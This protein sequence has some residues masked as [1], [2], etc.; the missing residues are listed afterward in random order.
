MPLTWPFCCAG[1]D[2]ASLLSIPFS[3][4]LNPGS[5][6]TVEVWVRPAAS[7]VS[8]GSS[9]V[10]PLVR[11][12]GSD[13]ASGYA[14]IIDTDGKFAFLLG[15]GNAST[16]P[17]AAKRTGMLTF[18]TGAYE[19][20]V[21]TASA[22]A[23]TWA[24]VSGT[25]EPGMMRLYVNG[26]AVCEEA[27][28]ETV[29]PNVDGD[30][31]LG[32]G[33]E[34]ASDGQCGNAT[35]HC[36][37]AAACQRRACQQDSTCSA[38]S[39]SLR[40]GGGYAGALDEAIVYGRCMSPAAVMNHASANSEKVFATVGASSALGALSECTGDCFLTFSAAS[41]P[42]LASVSPEFGWEG[43]TLTI[44]G[45]GFVDG[46]T[47]KV[48]NMTCA[49]VGTP[50]E[51]EI[52]C[53]LSTSGGVLG[54]APVSVLVPGKGR[55]SNSLAFTVKAQY[56]LA[57]D[58]LGVFYEGGASLTLSGEGLALGTPTVLVGTYAC[59]V[60]SQ[61]TKEIKCLLPLFEPSLTANSQPLPIQISLDDRPAIC[62]SG[63]TLSVVSGT[64][65]SLSAASPATVE[66][67]TTLTLTGQG[68]PV[69]GLLEV[70]VGG[71]ACTVTGT[72]S[73]TEVRLHT[74]SIQS[75]ACTCLGRPCTE[76]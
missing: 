36:A 31:I 37:A 33:C 8:S 62:L 25:W 47:V 42:S 4:A 70:L 20:C 64:P 61:T 27:T 5:G 11:A 24:H 46:T 43:S 23:D 66:E 59:S 18:A 9:T 44:V 63:C 51:T 49:V 10:R 1:L 39:E 40:V 69:A 65:P 56:S 67:G 28:G 2:G 38:A 26:V 12:V 60:A 6:L 17:P 48:G 19:V 76:I 68:L 22:V 72:P 41:T 73:A 74:S 32:G 75:Q 54:P 29:H 52:T 21:G 71:V 13:A 16:A 3:P 53:T 7:S 35:H 55:S 45:R 50:T 58:S 57:S 15:T 30:I 14:L 34:A